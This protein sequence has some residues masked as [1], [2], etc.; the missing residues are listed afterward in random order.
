MRIEQKQRD[1]GGIEVRCLCDTRE[2]RHTLYG[3]IL[4]EIKAAGSIRFMSSRA[5][6]F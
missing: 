5:G 6:L 4:I 2:W 3:D 1:F